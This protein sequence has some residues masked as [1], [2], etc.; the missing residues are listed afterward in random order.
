MK[1]IPGLQLSQIFYEEAVRP[2]LDAHFPDL[3]HAA[4]LLGHGSEVLGFDDETST[5]HHWG[6]R[7]QLFL[8]PNDEKTWGT[9]LLA[10]LADH[11][12][13]TIR[14][15][16]THYSEP[17]PN[18]GGVQHMRSHTGGPVNHR[19]EIHTLR[20]F[21]LS[22][23]NFDLEQPLEPADWLTFSEQHLRTL[24]AGAVFHD[25]IGL[26]AVRAQFAYYPDNVWR[27]VL[28]AGWARIGQD[29]HLMGRA[30]SREDEI[31]SAIIGARLVRDVMR[32][33]FWMERTYIP[34]PKWFG[35]AFQQL[36]CAKALTPYLQTALTAP[37]WQERERHLVPA[38]AH[39]ADM[40]NA[41]NLT[42]P[43]HAKATDFHGRGFRVIAQNGFADA[44][45]TSI[46]DPQVKGIAARQPIGSMEQF[47]DSTDLNSYPEWRKRVRGLYV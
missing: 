8:R 13:P 5:D 22:I 30:G 23:L 1:F 17:D 12:P 40:H 7:V 6:P 25:E 27:Y 43:I 41:L 45:T 33:G 3:P 11:L 2:L 24:T 20:G 9:R 18:D 21:V 47:S 35:T 4:A 28:A 34:Y 32:L 29:E 46:T 14:G 39:I 42:P 16:P 10:A 19:V 31:G 44:L 26:E 37:T 15:Y 36:D 38:Y